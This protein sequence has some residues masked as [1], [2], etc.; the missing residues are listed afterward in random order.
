MKTADIIRDKNY[1]KYLVIAVHPKAAYVC[2]LNNEGNGVPK[3]WKMI[4]PNDPQ[5][6]VLKTSVPVE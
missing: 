6:V 5:Y 2:P 1:D 3:N 4:D